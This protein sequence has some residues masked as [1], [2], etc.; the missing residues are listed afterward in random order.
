MLANHNVLYYF[1][2]WH[3]NFLYNFSSL[4]L[5]FLFYWNVI[6]VEYDL[7]YILFVFFFILI[8]FL[9]THFSWRHSLV[10]STKVVINSDFFVCIRNHPILFWIPSLDVHNWPQYPLEIK[11]RDFPRRLQQWGQ[12]TLY[13]SFSVC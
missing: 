3:C 7:F 9:S 1:S 4:F 12:C 2:C 5:L 13:N 6:S 11:L 10:T 8:N